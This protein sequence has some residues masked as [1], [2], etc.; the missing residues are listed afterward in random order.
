MTRPGAVL[1]DLD[2]TL[3]PRRASLERLAPLLAADF[4][5]ALGE[6][7]PDALL[8][9]LIAC[10]HGGYNPRRA[11]DL[12]EALPWTA[13]PAP[14]ALAD[15]WQQRFPDAVVPQ[16]GLHEVL[17]ALRAAGFR[18]GVVTNGEVR[19]QTRKLE[20][21]GVPERVDDVVISEAAG[22]KKPDARIFERAARGVGVA[23]AQCWFVGDH[24]E[25]DVLGA[26]RFGMRA[27]WITDPEAGFPWPPGEPAARH[28]VERL[29]ELLAI[30]AA[31]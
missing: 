30:V 23:A 27:V 2:G 17:E 11:E 6:I 14:P 31:G 10:D 20:R 13:P 15:Y 21:L 3:T 22:C 12:I 5:D 24:P 19:A 7:E 25:N 28:R 26:A 29:E 18:L 4:A 9:T 1:F 8:R 16:P